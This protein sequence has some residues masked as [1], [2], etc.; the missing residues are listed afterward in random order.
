MELGSNG[1]PLCRGHATG[2]LHGMNIVC[3]SH[4]A[5]PLNDAEAL[6]SARLLS[7]LVECGTNVHL[8][9]A[10]LPPSLDTTIGAELMDKRI[11]TTYV[12]AQTG[13]FARLAAGARFQ[14]H[15]QRVEWIA[16]AVN[17]TRA[18]LRQYDKPIL[19]TRAFPMVSNLVGYYCRQDAKAWVAHFSDPYPPFE[20]QNHWYSRF[21]RPIN[22]RWARRILK[23]ADLVTVTCPNAIRYIEE[24]SEISFRHKAEVVTHLALPKLKSGNFKLERKPDEFVVAY[25]GTMMT[26]RRPDLLLRGALLAMERHPEIR[27]LQ[28]GHVDPEIL[29]LCRSSP[30]FQRLD[31]RHIGNLSPRDAADL[32]AQVD[33]NLIVDT[34]LGLS[35]SP[36]ILSKFPHSVCVGRPMLM[37]S[38]ADSE[39]ARMTA[40]YHG[41]EFVPFSTPE[42]VA[43]AI[44]RL[45]DRRQQSVDSSKLM[46]YQAEFSPGRIVRPF[47][48]RL[49]QLIQ[50]S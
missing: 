26:R 33:V 47:F 11:K 2:N 36:F 30:A 7:A 16:P 42:A 10:E 22:R 44:C 45:F 5:P 21:V 15:S 28:F 25:I 39:M 31:I 37:I 49:K 35:Y 23:N 6:C 3:V 17:A 4:N 19:L 34:D 14:F 43:E 18:V 24:K 13:R 46:E 32:Q 9:A 48:E 29:E 12:S 27:F 8:I 40:K 20:W 38:A 41:G 50:N 1:Q